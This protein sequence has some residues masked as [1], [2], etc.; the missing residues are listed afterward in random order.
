ML[1]ASFEF[2]SRIF[3]R[4]TLFL[5]AMTPS[6]TLVAVGIVGYGLGSVSFSLLFAKAKGVDLRAVGSGNPGATNAS[7]AM[8]KKVGIAVYLLDMLKGF[9]PAFVCWEL[10][11]LEA[12]VVGGAGAYLGHILPFWNGFRGGK[13]VATLSGALLALQP[14]ATLTAGVTWLLVTRIGGLVALGSL[15][16]GVALPIAAWIFDSDPWVFWFALGGGLFLFVTH[17]SNLKRMMNGTED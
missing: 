13:G 15:A 16:F 10:W 9:L 2:G 11:G 17:R 6:M 4:A 7:R 5:P 14:W 8:G 12:G 3:F 1:I